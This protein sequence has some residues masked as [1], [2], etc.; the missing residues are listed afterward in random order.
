MFKYA[1][2]SLSLAALWLLPWPVSLNAQGDDV[3][4]HDLAARPGAPYGPFPEAW[5]VVTDSNSFA[6]CVVPAGFR[7]T[8]HHHNQEQVVIGGGGALE[9]VIG[10]VRHVLGSRAAGLPPANVAHNMLNE[11]QQQAIM[12]EFQPVRRAEWI[13]PHPRV[14]PQPQS[15]QPMPLPPDA[16]TTVDFAL[17]SEGW[18]SSGKGLRTKTL[19]G[20]QIR[21]TFLDLSA[22][23]SSAEMTAVPR[24]NERFVFVLSG[25]LDA[26]V[27]GTRRA[28]G[29]RMLIVIAPSAKGVSL[30]S[31]GHAGT[32]V[33]IF[34]A[35]EPPASK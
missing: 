25:Q 34:E 2:L 1:A 7:Q 20:K 31:T 11:S 33:V 28:V 16:R 22:S 30:H 12:M 14:A 3:V 5:T 27:S 9:F 29:P 13:P 10:G 32:E 17:T 18:K 26:V 19:T 4:F 8:P 23:N 15:P 6:Y 24:V 21:A 35:L